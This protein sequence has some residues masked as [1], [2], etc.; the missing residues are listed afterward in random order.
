MHLTVPKPKE[1]GSSAS[2]TPNATPESTATGSGKIAS[3]GSGIGPDLETEAKRVSDIRPLLNRLTRISHNLSQILRSH[4]S[5][6][7]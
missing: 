7:Y 2:P 1:E 5:K 3:R 4:R 6:P